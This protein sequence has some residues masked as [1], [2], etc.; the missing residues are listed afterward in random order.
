MTEGLDDAATGLFE[1]LRAWRAATARE[2]G[3]PAYVVFHD[4][5][6]WL[7]ASYDYCCQGVKSNYRVVVGRSAAITGPYTDRSGQS[8]ISPRDGRA[9]ADDP[10]TPVLAG[11]GSTYGPGHE[12]VLHDGENWFLVHH[13]YN[14]AR[15]WKPG[16]AGGAELGIRPLDW[17]ADGWP[18]ARGWN[19]SL[20]P[21][22]AP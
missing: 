6:W 9:L 4:G 10:G 18:V 17:G 20:P 15:E 21:P 2:Q 7:F 11:Y 19:P 1:A 13:W 14:P 12:S 16:L 3:V 8:M 22:P 5:Y